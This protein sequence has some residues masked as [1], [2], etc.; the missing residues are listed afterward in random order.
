MLLRPTLEAG[1]F[2]QGWAKWLC[3]DDQMSEILN[4]GVRSMICSAASSRRRLPPTLRLTPPPPTPPRTRGSRCP[5]AVTSC[6]ARGNRDTLDPDT[7][8]VRWGHVMCYVLLQD[9][10]NALTLTLKIMVVCGGWDGDRALES[11]E[12]FSPRTGQWSP[13][14]NMLGVV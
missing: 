8:R 1:D 3:H 13:L 2:R 12:M 4:Q 7:P 14:P 6:R 5:E 11:V 10:Y 9:T